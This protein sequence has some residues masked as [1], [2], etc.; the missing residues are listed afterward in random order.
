[1]EDLTPQQE[2][3]LRKALKIVE[4]G[5][6][7]I[8]EAI[9]DLEEKFDEVVKDIKKTAPDVNKMLE[10]IKGKDGENG[11]DGTDYVITEDDK[12]EIATEVETM[13]D[14]DSIAQEAV[15]LIP[16]Q[17]ISDKISKNIKV[18]VVEKIVEKTEVIRETPIVTENVVQIAVADTAEVTVDKINELPTDTDEHKIDASHIKNLPAPTVVKGGFRGVG[19][20]DGDK[21]DV[22]VS[23]NGKTFTLD[24]PYKYKVV[25]IAVDPPNVTLTTGD[26]QA[27]FRVNS[28]FD[29]WQLIAVAAGLNA[30]S[31][32][33]VPTIQIR[34]HSSDLDMLSTKLTI[35]EN[36]MDSKDA[37]TP[38]V[39]EPLNRF[40]ATG[41]QIHVDV[42][43]AGTG[44][45]G[46]IVELTIAPA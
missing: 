24:T 25:Q 35:D 26:E 9:F 43:I 37:T 17:E 3:K 45:K 22:V 14:K 32:S 39:I 16:L 7:G 34:N 20:T 1:M 4:D 41:D 29:G 18:P 46:L 19:L 40:M 12:K 30:V 10:S 42:D 13:L 31:T 11:A 23:N 33:G 38:A 28:L 15:K 6:L 21:G 36:E 2:K 5:N 8:A 44:A 27:T